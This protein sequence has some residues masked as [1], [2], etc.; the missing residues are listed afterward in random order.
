M[1][2]I[3]CLLL[4]TCWFISCSDKNE[5]TTER[6]LALLGNTSDYFSNQGEERDLSV[7]YTS[8]PA[9]SDKDVENLLKSSEITFT[10]KN[11]NFSF[12]DYS[13]SG[14]EVKFKVICE[15]NKSIY[16]IEDKISIR[17]TNQQFNMEV[18]SELK[19][20]GGA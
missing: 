14:N 12:S 13:I 16:I 2:K 8:T 20:S 17:I 3:I 11:N 9:I 10:S 18:S 15:E 19:Q 1:R 4:L 6:I 7:K 5:T